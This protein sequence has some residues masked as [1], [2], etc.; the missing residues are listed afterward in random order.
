MNRLKALLAIT[1]IL[2]I[3]GCTDYFMICSLNP[4]YLDKNVVLIHELEGKWSARPKLARNPSGKNE[5]SPVWKQ[6]DTTYA[7]KI[8]RVISEQTVKSKRGKDS[9]VFKPMDSY[10]VSLVGSQADSSIYKF[11]MVLF[12][13]NK[14]LYAD[15]MPIGNTGLERSRFA[16]ESYFSVH[17]LARVDLHSHQ[18]HI[19]WLGAEYMKDMV[20]KKRVRVKYQW[21]ESAKRLLLTGTP[22]QLTNMIDRYA[23]ERRFIDWDNQQ[24]M[25][26]LNRIK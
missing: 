9:T 4:F 26:T 19:S 18:V 1:I 22:E 7:W 23:G 24:A 6:V 8:E 11:N 5:T 17:T 25:L 3:S 15:F 20:E 2:F 13:V 10:T 16:T 14:I 21:V 12:R